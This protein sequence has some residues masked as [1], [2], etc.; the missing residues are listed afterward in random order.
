ME[1]RIIESIRR[2]IDRGENTFYFYGEYIHDWYF[3]NMFRGICNF[4]DTL[5]YSFFE[6]NVIDYFIY[7]KN[8]EILA[9]QQNDN[10]EIQECSKE[11][12]EGKKMEGSVTA[13]MSLDNVAANQNEKLS[14]TK[15]SSEANAGEK[16]IESS[17]ASKGKA[18]FRKAVEYCKKN[19]NKRVLFFF[20]DYEWT[21]GMYRSSNDDELSYIESAKELSALKNTYVVYSMEEIKLLEQ[22]NFHISGNNVIMIGS[23]SA[24]EVFSA[25]LRIYARKYCDNGFDKLGNSF[26]EELSRVSEAI[27][28]GEK[29]LK[30]SIRIFERVMDEKKGELNCTDFS[31]SLDNI[32]EEKVYLDDVVLDIT[33]KEEAVA[34]VDRFLEAEQVSEVTKGMILTGPPGTGKTYL[35]KAL[36][37]EKNCYFMSASLADLKAEYV[38][39]SAH[40]IKR[41]FQKAR[42]N[43]PTILFIDEADTIFPSRD[44]AGDSDSFTK[45]MVNQFLVEMDGMLT[46]DSKVFVIAATNRINI[47]DRAIKSR[48]GKPIEI[49]LPNKSERKALFTKLLKNKKFEFTKYGFTDEFL[50]KT[51][52]MSGRDIK[53]FVNDLEKE[54]RKQYK[55][56]SDYQKED[57]AR[58]LFYS[59]LKSFEETLVRELEESLGITISKPDDSVKY[60]NIIGCEDIKRAIDQ[61]ILMFNP[62]QR[63]KAEEY[64]I[65]LKRGILLYG[66]PGNGKSQIAKAA[67]NEHK[68]YFMKITSD[69]FTK[70]SLSEQNKT[71]IKIFNSALQL[72]E[73]CGE[74]IKG[75]LLFFDEFDSLASTE[76]LDSR[77]RGTMLTQLDDADS[78]RNPKTKVLFMAATNFYE[79]LDEAMIRSGRIDD[80]LEMKNPSEDDGAK[81]LQQ[82]CASNPKVEVLNGNE[83]IEAYKKF[84]TEYQNEKKKTYIESQKIVWLMN[85]KPLDEL[86]KWGDEYCKNI[87]PSGADLKN[88]SERLIATA[89]YNSSFSDNRKLRIDSDII[90]KAQ[91]E[92]IE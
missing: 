68:L 73:M 92:E 38:G 52:H 14:K 53:D 50:D 20:E 81:M 49:P 10:K 16:A 69:T 74:D 24:Q 67:A 70:I 65:K 84:K 77:V 9:F 30:E 47:L 71:L 15:Q 57:E 8:D 72:S 11:L 79:R 48:L 64:R 43:A 89:F 58:E 37:N 88:Y 21:T 76:I 61:Q 31:S 90:N 22:Y 6:E 12:F 3:Y 26:I 62:N 56:L 19:K 41:I 86:E 29:S 13:G 23:P 54:V 4:V 28:K 44:Q 34:R 80:K 18:T 32:I 27:A 39:Q 82:F 87:R 63:R 51:N 66:P 59:C 17:G 1:N 35:V 45:D 40:K 55:K 83:A 36:A 60:S 78:F 7:C 33:I 75:V 25:F 5:K 42:A 46:G 91:C 85:N 2:E